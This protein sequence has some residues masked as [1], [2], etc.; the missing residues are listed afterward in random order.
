MH[1]AASTGNLHVLRLLIENRADLILDER[2]ETPFNY[3]I[4]A[5]NIECIK[6][7]RRRFGTAKVDKLD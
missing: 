4:R 3:A 1:L 6:L 7:L 5:E 2:R